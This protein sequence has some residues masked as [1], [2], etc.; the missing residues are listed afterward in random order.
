MPISKVWTPAEWLRF[1]IIAAMIALD[2]ILLATGPMRLAIQSIVVPMLATTGLLALALW[3]RGRREATL[4]TILAGTGQLIAFTAAGATLNYALIALDRPLMD[5]FF[6]RVDQA[7]GIHW[8]SLFATA[9]SMPWL[10]AILSTAYISTLVQVALMV[11][12]L[13]FLKRIAQLDHFLLAL[14]VSLL[15][16]IGVWALFPSFGA[17]PHLYASGQMTDFPGAVL[18]TDYA[19]LMMALKAGQIRDF[20]LSDAEGLIGFPSYHTVMAVLIVYAV[21]G[22]RRVFWPVLVWNILVIAS[23]PV[24][25]A[26]NVADVLGGLAVAGISIVVCHRLLARA[27]AKAQAPLDIGAA[28]PA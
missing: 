18:G 3:Y 26:H 27:A 21:R 16:T 4:S 12:L 2:A 1:Q 14:M 25:G 24:D 22:I 28:A 6:Y 13:G 9:K 15:L 7:L 8:P 5:P 11:P 23:V 19:R 20:S 17:G 10:S